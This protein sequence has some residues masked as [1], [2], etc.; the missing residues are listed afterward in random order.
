LV[1]AAVQIKLAGQDAPVDFAWDGGYSSCPGEP[2]EGVTSVGSSSSQV[3]ITVMGGDSG[4][5]DA[6]SWFLSKVS[7]DIDTDGNA[8]TAPSELAYAFTGTLSINGVDFPAVMGRTPT[9]ASASEV[10]LIGGEEWTTAVRTGGLCTSIA[11]VDDSPVQ[12]YF[13]PVGP[14]FHVLPGDENCG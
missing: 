14:Y 1:L 8:N 2:W 12:Y 11:T 4:C 9:S 10:W 7:G 6:A 13:A 5:A 3:M